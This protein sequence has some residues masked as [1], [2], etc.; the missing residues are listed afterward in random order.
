MYA[1][2]GNIYPP[3]LAYIPYMDPMGNYSNYR[4]FCQLKTMEFLMVGPPTVMLSGSLMGAGMIVVTLL[5]HGEK[6]ENGVYPN[7]DFSISMVNFSG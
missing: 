1:I 3:M 7:A 5:S 4:G 6:S 2:Y